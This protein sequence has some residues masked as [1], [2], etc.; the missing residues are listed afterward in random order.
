VVIDVDSRQLPE[1]A[2]PE[3]YPV[4]QETVN[5]WKSGWKTSTQIPLPMG[6]VLNVDVLNTPQ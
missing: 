3:L 1:E 2:V 5:G 4:R 6:I